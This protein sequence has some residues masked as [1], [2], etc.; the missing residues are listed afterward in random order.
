[1]VKLAFADEGTKMDR[2]VDEYGYEWLKLTDEDFEDLVTTIHV[3]AQSMTDD[4]FGEQLLCAVFGFEP[5]H[6]RFIYN[7]KRGTF[8]PF[9]PLAEPEARLRARAAAA[10]QARAGAADR[11]RARALVPALGRP[12]L[13][14]RTAWAASRWWVGETLCPSAGRGSGRCWR[15]RLAS[16]TCVICGSLTHPRHPVTHASH[17]PRHTD[18]RDVDAAHPVQG[19]QPAAE[20]AGLR[21]LCRSHARTHRRGA[22]GLSRHRVA[23][24]RSR[25]AGVPDQARRHA[26]S[27]AP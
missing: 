17:P 26:T 21:D 19:A 7:F 18:L 13:G 11:G 27:C 22:A 25:R 16:R 4:G 9:V 5:G 10:G 14:S 3:A 12:G 1:M 2:S 23:L 15:C 24:P 8:Y 20:A 6:V